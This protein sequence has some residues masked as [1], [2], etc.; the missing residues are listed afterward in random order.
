MSDITRSTRG[1]RLSNLNW[2]YQIVHESQVLAAIHDT[3]RGPTRT[4]E[5]SDEARKLY[6]Q[7]A[8]LYERLYS[9]RIRKP[10]QLQLN[11]LVSVI[12]RDSGKPKYWNSLIALYERG[13]IV[14]ADPNDFGYTGWKP[15]Y[16]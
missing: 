10:T 16:E 2:G 1:V 9:S 8:H 11:T 12:R 15:N 5:C 13:V 7:I 4:E 14:R 3:I 6:E